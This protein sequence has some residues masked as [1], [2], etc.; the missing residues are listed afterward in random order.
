MARLAVVLISVIALGLSL[1][2]NA[3]ARG[4]VPRGFVGTVIGPPIY[5]SDTPAVD[6]SSALDTMASSGVESLRFVANWSYAQPYASWA[7]VPAA[8]KSL[9]V[10]AGGVPTRF[11]RLDEIVETAARHRLNLL[12]T[13]LYAPSWDAAPVSVTSYPQPSSVIPYANF[14]AA[15]VHRYGPDGS[16][17]QNHSPRVPI[18]MWQIWNEPNLSVFW[19]EQPFASSYVA[20]L[21]AAHAAIKQA[22][23]GARVVLAGM[24][25]Y[26]WLSLRQIYAVPGASRLFDVVAVH[27]YTRD[28]AGV[29][30]IIRKI[31]RVMD[32]SGD[33]R[34]PIVADEVSWPSSLGRT[35]HNDGYDF[36]TTQRGQA[37]NI[38]ALLPMLARD[39][40]QLGLLGFDYYDWAG[41]EQRGG[42]V[43]DFAGL[44][45][46][47]T[48]GLIAKPAFHA[49][50]RAA[51]AMERCRRKGSVATLC[52][53]R[54]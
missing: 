2:G 31:R 16:F 50:R 36:A 47:T 26:S 44:F 52:S 37:R 11:D 49:F 6:L 10:D 21:A 22:D 17:W 20:L 1:A 3:G 19:P 45:R 25:N 29:I 35:R 4:R 7:E 33:R 28:P 30:T 23:P 41:A 27:P 18:R 43:F 8:Q 39:R 12:P 13:V 5:T 32:A 48:S 38:A 46:F 54:G 34:K 14:L 53:K 42:P 24:P 51:L 9:Y 15:L 40:R